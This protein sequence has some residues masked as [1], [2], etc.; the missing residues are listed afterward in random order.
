MKLLN[1]TLTN[2]GSYKELEFDFSDLGLA[3]VYGATGSG[4]S[5]LLDAAPWVLFGITAKEGNVDDVRSWGVHDEPTTGILTVETPA[6]IICVHRIRGSSSQNDLSWWEDD[7]SASPRRGKDIKDT[8]RLLNE[9]LGVT[10]D[11]YLSAAYAS[12]FSPTAGFFLAS[13][14]RQREIFDLV[15]DLSFP[16]LLAERATDVRKE[17]KK[18]LDQT[19]RAYAKAVGRFEELL[20]S[21]DFAVKQAAG[22]KES[23]ARTIKELETRAQ[24]FEAEKAQ[25]LMNLSRQSQ[26]WEREQ[27]RLAKEQRE[28]K[29][30]PTCNRP[31]YTRPQK[32]LSNPVNPFLDRIEDVEWSKS[33]YPHMIK[34]AKEAGN[35]HHATVARLDGEIEKAD[36]EAT[37][38]NDVLER[39]QSK[40]SSLTQLIDI[41]SD[42]RGALLTQAVHDIQDETNRILETYFD[43][44]IMVNFSLDGDSLDVFI[45]KNGYSCTYSQLSK[46]QRQLLKLSFMI[47]VM[48]AAANTAGVSFGQ[49]MLDESLDGLDGDLKIKAHGLF[50]ELSQT[51][52]VLVI[53]HS[54]EL[55]EL[56][57]T[58]YRVTL[59]GDHSEVE[60]E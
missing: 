48:K 34:E 47:S 30:C 37:A 28:T 50:Q 40:I 16:I 32:S 20:R 7:Y 17:A 51:R 55:R 4:K 29:V 21:K 56:F 45:R 42:L 49:V 5:S 24:N 59:V 58:R 44:E 3:L 46:G 36:A 57:D 52:G 2:F 11:L 12:E 8:Q 14:K 39:L 10:P 33:G 19:Q 1:C 27:S 26:E 31:G 35:P 54:S 18:E 6:G 41:S 60:R 9:R 38:Q 13:A 25:K 23:Q 43:G 53:D 22:W 15:A